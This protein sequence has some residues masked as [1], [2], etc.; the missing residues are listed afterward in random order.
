MSN[1]LEMIQNEE[2]DVDDEYKDNHQQA[3]EE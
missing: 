3:K 2:Q 1:Q